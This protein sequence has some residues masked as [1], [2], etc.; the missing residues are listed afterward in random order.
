MVQFFERDEM[1]FLLAEE[2]LDKFNPIFSDYL[3][4]ISTFV[5]DDAQSVVKRLGI[6]LFRLCMIFTAIRK[7]DKKDHQQE[8]YC[9][10]IDFE[11][12][13]TLI[14]TYLQHSIIMFE[15]LPKHEEGGVFKSGQNKKLFF[16]AL[17]KRFTRGQAIELAKNF[18]IAERTVGTFLKSC[19][20]KYLQQPEY[21]VYA[22]I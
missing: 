3:V 9:S 6:I 8:V 5:S 18:N 16:D 11:T 4:Q 2:Q 20:E 17:P 7:F 14:K 10:D 21:G 12:A 22:K 19:L 13:L 1:I 15:N